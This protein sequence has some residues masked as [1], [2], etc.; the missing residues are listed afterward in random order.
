MANAKKK[1]LKLGLLNARSLNTGKDE[2]IVTMLKYK[3]DI[4]AINETW[5][6]EG[7][8][9]LAPEVP[10]YKFVHR[11]RKGR[12][13]GGVG[14]YVG[15]E[16]SVRTRQHP[17]AALEQLWLE[18]QLPGAALALGTAYRPDS[19]PVRDALDALSESICCMSHCDYVCVLGDMNIDLAQANSSKVLEFTTFCREHGLDQLVKEPTRVTD[20]TETILDLVITDCIPKVQNLQIIH[21][22]CLSDHAMVLTDFDIKKPKPIKIFKYR[23]FIKDINVDYFYEDLNSIP[24]Q[25]ICNLNSIDDMID[26]FN[27]YMLSLFEIHA[28]M[29]KLIIKEKP[30][31]WITDTVKFMM[32]LRDEALV[33]AQ[34]SKSDS[35]KNYYRSLRNL[36]TATR[37]RE[38][39]AYFN[40]FINNNIQN[41]NLLWKNI[42]TTTIFDNS[43]TNS[44]PHHLNDPNKINDHFL[45]LP[46]INETVLE[47]IIGDKTQYQDSFKL[48]CTSESKV[49]K[50]IN[51]I[52][53]KATGHDNLNI[54]MIKLTLDVTLP[55]ITSIINRSIETNTFPTC[56]KRSIVKPI[57]KKNVV[58]ELKDLR[59]ISI[60]PVL[61][62]VLEKVIL[63]QILEHVE[64]INVIPKFQSGFRRGHSTETALLHVTDDL[65]AAS[66]Q[67]LSSIMVLLDYSRAFDCLHPDLLLAK[68]EH[69]GFSDDT[70][71]WFKTYLSNRE[72]AVVTEDKDGEMR[73]SSVKT[74]ERGVPQGSLLSPILFSIFTADL[75]KYIQS[76]KFHFYA[77]DIQLY[78]SFEGKNTK[79]AIAHINN[80]LKNIYTWSERNSLILN[81][82]KSQVLVLGTKYQIKLVK[83]CPEKIK[84]NGVVLE[85]VT[86]ARNLGLILDGELKYAEHVSGKIKTAFYKLKTLYKI[87]PYIK[88]ELRVLLTD[89]LVL[90]QFNYCSSVFGPRLNSNTDRAIQR[91]QNACIRFCYNIPRRDHIT[92]YLNKKGIL[93]MGARRELLY[94]CTVQRVIWNKKPE[95][96]F[97]KLIWIKDISQRCHRSTTQNLLSIPK[98]KTTRYRGC[99]R[100]NAAKIWND[101]PPPMRQKMSVHCFKT[102]FKSALLKKQLAAENLKHAYWDLLS[103]KDYF[104]AF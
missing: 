50:I 15:R 35:S 57:P 68:L 58:S 31:P 88:E 38:K 9:S 53:T 46:T 2:F 60:L 29:K 90:S 17:A 84:I 48:K 44:I 24:W 25:S 18:V 94:A 26:T 32:S 4:I 75:P 99:F 21:N 45:N 55:I 27:F 39:K 89:S 104:P 74:V 63:E 82:Q 12:R 65:L 42:K 93:N 51:N 79:D 30:K 96:L 49:T 41:P 16:M 77:D 101:L 62:K 83:E 71:R 43:H 1:C 102:K 34:R 10:G 100:F 80:D 91:V 40:N 23:R 97:D 52:K 6:R 56:W 85:Q 61:S 70:C 13:G 3:P 76:C 59:P 7:E 72:Q 87:R 54:D 47:K 20:C 19:V 66:D 8:E 33:K 103:L 11:A 92:P 78:F 64:K 67:G 98:H 14:F 73:F 22:R 69:Y 36:V 5:L 28:P 37:Q 95:Y 86:S 81:P